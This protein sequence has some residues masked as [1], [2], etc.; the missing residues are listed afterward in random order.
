MEEQIRDILIRRAK[1]I[2]FAD[3]RKNGFGVNISK[4]AEHANMT[5]STVYRMLKGPSDPE[6]SQLERLLLALN[7]PCL[8]IYKDPKNLII[9]SQLDDLSN[10]DKDSLIKFLHGLKE[11]KPA[12]EHA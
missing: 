2:G 9:I 1:Q 7:I 5:Y 10:N 4:L 3:K 8:D 12:E 6:Y 11:Y